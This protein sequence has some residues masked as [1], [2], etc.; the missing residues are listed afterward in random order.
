M[1]N[2]A[3]ILKTKDMTVRLKT[4]VSTAMRAAD[5]RENFV[6]VL[7]GKAMDVVFRTNDAG[8]IYGVTFIDHENRVVVNGSRLGK[9]FSANVFNDLFN[10][11]KFHPSISPI[12]PV[13]PNSSDNTAPEKQPADTSLFE[14]LFGLFD[15]KPHGEDFNEIAFARKM[16]KKKRKRI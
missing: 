5:T 9:K 12:S 8:R 11:S 16:R 2:N 6:K 3:E 1:K 4:V 13:S 7:R 15:M 14:E 10:A